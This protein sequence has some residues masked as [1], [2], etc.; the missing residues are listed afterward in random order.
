MIVM[1]HGALILQAMQLS[2]WNK[3]TLSRLALSSSM[4][5]QLTKTTSGITCSTHK[6]HL[7][8]APSPHRGD[9]CMKAHLAAA[10]AAL[11]EGGRPGGQD[12]GVPGPHVG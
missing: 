8:T 4:L 1:E 9:M 2:C 5:Q 7:N 11:P 12:G 3:H 6:L 10:G